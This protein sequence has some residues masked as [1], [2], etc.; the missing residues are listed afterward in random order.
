[1]AP[2]C[3]WHP[4]CG[5]DEAGSLVKEGSDEIAEAVGVRKWDD[6]EIQVVRADPYRLA[7]IPTIGQQ[8]SLSRPNSPGSA[9]GAGS[10]LEQIGS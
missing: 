5:T 9:S 8:L 2:D 6:A 7:D 4:V 3:A 1:M 10:D